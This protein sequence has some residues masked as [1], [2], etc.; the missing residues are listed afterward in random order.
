MQ[1]CAQSGYQVLGD[2]RTEEKAQK[3]L[4]QIDGFLSHSVSKDKI[5]EAEKEAVLGRIKYTQRLE[6]FSGCDLAI[7]SAIED[8][9]LKKQ[10]F[11]ELDKSC[12]AQ[13]I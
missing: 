5:T 6:D 7:E 3:A 10:L 4:A 12:P 13:A 9:E 8:L 11:A 2:S 1:R